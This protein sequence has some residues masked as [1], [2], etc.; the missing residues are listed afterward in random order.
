[1]HFDRKD[2]G[3]RSRPCNKRI[4]PWKGPEQIRPHFIAIQRRMDDAMATPFQRFRAS[5]TRTIREA[6]PA[7]G[8]ND[9]IFL[10]IDLI[11]Y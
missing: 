5:G 1:M 7:R 8:R 9:G 10:P 11:R 3:F 4:D 6:F 2:V